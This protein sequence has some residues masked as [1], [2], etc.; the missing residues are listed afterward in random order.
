M[1]VAD[2]RT[3]DYI[4]STPA[5]STILTP[6][7][8]GFALIP[9]TD[10]EGTATVKD[11]SYEQE[12]SFKSPVCV[13]VHGHYSGTFQGDPQAGDY[14]YRIDLTDN[15]DEH[16]PIFRNFTYGI[17]ISD[18]QKAGYSSAGEAYQFGTSSDISA[19]VRYDDLKSIENGISQISVQYTEIVVTGQPGTT[20]DPVTLMYQFIPD[21]ADDSTVANAPEAEGLASYVTITPGA[22]S[23]SGAAFVDD[24]ATTW[25]TEMSAEPVD[26]WNTITIQPSEIQTETIAQDLIIKGTTTSSGG[27]KTTI[28]RTV[29]IIILPAKPIILAPIEPVAKTV[30]T[31]VDVYISLPGGLPSSMFP[32]N[33]YI[34]AEQQTLS[35][36]PGEPLSVQSGRSSFN[37]IKPGVKFVRT[38][39][40]DEYT[41]ETETDADPDNPGYI[42]FI[43]PCR[44]KTAIAESASSIRATAD[45]LQPGDTYFLNIKSFDG[46]FASAAPV[47][48]NSTT[49]LTFT[50]DVISPV[51][52]TLVDGMTGEGLTSFVYTPTEVG[53]QTI[54]GIRATTKYAPITMSLSAS[55]Y[56]TTTIVARRTAT[57]ASGAISLSDTGS[58]FGVTGWNASNTAT[59]TITATSPSISGSV[60]ITGTVTRTVTGTFNAPE[61]TI[62]RT[63]SKQDGKTRYTFTF[64]ITNYDS[65]CSYY[66]STDSSTGENNRTQI[67]S[68]TLTIN[69]QKNSSY[70][71]YIWAKYNDGQ[72]SNQSTFSCNSN[73]ANATQGAAK[74]TYSYSFSGPSV[75]T[76]VEF[77]DVPDD[78]EILTLI[79]EDE[80]TGEIT[81]GDIF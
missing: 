12:Q 79:Y 66:Y 38:V 20:P 76:S 73:S 46:G 27:K 67:Q 62:T 42:K 59:A 13:I 64:T 11:Y 29:K 78:S 7:S 36:M 26:G 10:M 39:D 74:Y 19:D 50:I 49:T 70:T 35:P 6:S 81:F 17:I 53:E 37:S 14:F 30:G 23:A 65:N 5:N 40:I 4:G 41:S 48:M 31:E 22:E 75:A 43:R 8:E 68:N 33:I 71:I 28:Q 69:N 45:R 63:S 3:A 51:T 24:S 61:G 16:Y 77:V 2:L 18:I 1:S 52:I 60:D 15:D 9:A 54:S 56:A 58:D 72:W 57:I 34:E 47:G 25:L 21:V 44:F 32:M 55:G 80:Y